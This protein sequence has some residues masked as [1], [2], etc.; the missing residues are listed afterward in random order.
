MMAKYENGED[1]DSNE[2]RLIMFHLKQMNHKSVANAQYLAYF[3]NEKQKTVDKLLAKSEQGGAMDH[4][5]Q[6]KKAATLCY[7]EFFHTKI[8]WFTE[9][10]HEAA[11]ATNVCISSVASMAAKLSIDWIKKPIFEEII[12]WIT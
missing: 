1:I 6:A 4:F 5:L 7:E 2:F 3:C 8:S 11:N 10:I 9:Y 12:P